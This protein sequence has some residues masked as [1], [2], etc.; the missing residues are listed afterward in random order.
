M[1]LAAHVGLPVSVGA[2]A[3]GADDSD[4][5][6]CTDNAFG[7]LG[8]LAARGVLVLGAGT[9]SGGRVF[10]AQQLAMD[11][12]VFSWSARIAA[13]IRVDQDTLALEAIKQVGIGGNYLGQ[14]H[15]RN[16]MRQVWRPRLLDRSVWETWV[17]SGREGAFEKA[18][19]LVEQL[20]GSHEVVPLDGVTGGVLD[21]IVVEAGL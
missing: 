1:Q 8:A 14:R 21:D 18:S 4:W 19:A 12:E 10:S 3:T 7:A 13:G 2:L 6:S 20:L 5:Q 16:H 15:T 9:L 17:A 11:A